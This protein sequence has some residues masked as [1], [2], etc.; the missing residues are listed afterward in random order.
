[1]KS[2]KIIKISV[3]V[4]AGLAI[5]GLAAVMLG[6]NTAQAQNAVPQAGVASYEESYQT[7]LSETGYVS[8]SC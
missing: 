2:G 7:Y 6:N 3:C 8:G 5:I 4:I 1:M